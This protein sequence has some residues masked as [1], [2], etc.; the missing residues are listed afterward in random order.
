MTTRF[1]HQLDII[2]FLKDYQS[3]PCLWDKSDVNI[4]NKV[5]R[6]IAEGVLM[7]TFGFNDIKHLKMKIRSLRYVNLLKPFK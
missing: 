4:K 7:K 3:Y 2:K 1:D 6:N 5:Q